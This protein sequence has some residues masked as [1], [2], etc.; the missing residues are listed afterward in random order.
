MAQLALQRDCGP[1]G[2]QKLGMGLSRIRTAHMCKEDAAVLA[3]QLWLHVWGRLA[4]RTVCGHL[5]EAQ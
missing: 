1:C 5:S 2:L 4:P 3:P